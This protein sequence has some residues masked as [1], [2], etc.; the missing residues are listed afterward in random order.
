MSSHLK[1]IP[2]FLIWTIKTYKL[3]FIF[4]TI[5]VTHQLYIHLP[6]FNI[7][8][9]CLDNDVFE[10]H[11]S[12][13]ISMLGAIIVFLSINSNLSSFKGV[14]FWKHSKLIFQTN[15]YYEKDVRKAILTASFSS[16]NTSTSKMEFQ[17][18]T[19][20]ELYQLMNNKFEN[21]QAEILKVKSEMQTQITDS[22]NE[23]KELHSNGHKNIIDLK[24]KVEHFAIGSV[25]WQVFGVLLVLYASYL[26]IN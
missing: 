10:S 11:L 5:L 22:A 7:G 25:D 4:I 1:K 20:E 3:F 21:Q 8:I 23:L 17:P 14:N 12:T 6:C 13:L 26:N 15:P 19:L 9:S 2:L 16:V 24:Q 18:D